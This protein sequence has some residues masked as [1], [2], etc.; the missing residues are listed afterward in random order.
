M[1]A[2]LWALPAVAEEGPAPWMLQPLRPPSRLAIRD[3]SLRVDYPERGTPGN[4][5][6]EAQAELSNEY[7]SAC[8]EQFLILNG[9]AASR[10]SWKGK[11]LKQDRLV[12]QIPD[13]PG[14]EMTRVSIFHL[15][16]L[17]QEKGVLKFSGLHRLDFGAPNRHRLRLIFPLRRA[18]HHVG[19][20]EVQVALAPELDLLSRDF[21]PVRGQ[22]GTFRRHFGAYSKA[23]ELSVEAKLTGPSWLGAVGVIPALRRAWLLGGVAALLAVTFAGLSQR[24]WWLAVPLSLLLNWGMLRQDDT[25][26][27][28]TYFEDARAYKRALDL[29][30]YLVPLWAFLGGLGVAVLGQTK[31]TK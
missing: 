28:W 24:R 11:E 22:P 20:S 1:L 23:L 19:E 2:A 21:Q 27:Q 30:W 15:I 13:S 25:V 3:L 26:Q 12:M 5:R 9:D 6:V 31:E 14:Q 29:Q 17:P 16:L 7:A 18:W 10:V 8:D 4:V